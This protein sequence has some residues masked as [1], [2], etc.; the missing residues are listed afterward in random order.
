MPIRLVLLLLF[1]KFYPG[2]KVLIDA[3]PNK[4]ASCV[5]EKISDM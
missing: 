4:S 3:T 2:F 1:S 5:A